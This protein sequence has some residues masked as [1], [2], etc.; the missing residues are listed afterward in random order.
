MIIFFLEFL[1]LNINIFIASMKILN[2]S[3]YRLSFFRPINYRLL[4]IIVNRYNFSSIM[5]D[6]FVITTTL[7]TTGASMLHFIVQ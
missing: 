6:F 7:I 1:N 4:S 5:M 2:L 3:I